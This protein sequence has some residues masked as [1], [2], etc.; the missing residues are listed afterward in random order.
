[1]PV[2][3]LRFSWNCLIKGCGDSRCDAA[4]E[5]EDCWISLPLATSEARR[6]WRFQ[7]SKYQPRCSCWS[8]VRISACRSSGSDWLFRCHSRSLW[9]TFWYGTDMLLTSWNANFN[10]TFLW[11]RKVVAAK[12]VGSAMS[13][14]Q[15]HDKVCYILALWLEIEL[16][17]LDFKSIAL[18]F[19]QLRQSLSQTY[20]C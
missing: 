11:C 3:A 9:Q 2:R 19:M 8:V 13:T 20:S 1:M 12:A 7:L 10:D 4:E 15:W 18:V 17:L 5:K 14:A 6:R 16:C